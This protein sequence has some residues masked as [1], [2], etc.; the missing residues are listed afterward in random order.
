MLNDLMDNK[1]VRVLLRLLFKDQLD[2][3][4]KM[5][6]SFYVIMGPYPDFLPN[7][8]PISGGCA[9]PSELDATFETNSEGS[10]G[11]LIS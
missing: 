5:N 8:L 4:C 2:T 7:F 11:Q 9:F 1:M 6:T 10:R 3:L